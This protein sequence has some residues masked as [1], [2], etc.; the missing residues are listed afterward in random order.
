MYVLCKKERDD[1][2]KAAL[3]EEKEQKWSRKSVKIDP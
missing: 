1:E 2:Q 3:E